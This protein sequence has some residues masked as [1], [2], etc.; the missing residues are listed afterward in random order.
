MTESIV[1]WSELHYPLLS[2]LR[3][4]VC[5]CE[6]AHDVVLAI[7]N[8]TWVPTNDFLKLCVEAMALSEDSE[9]VNERLSVLV[10]MAQSANPNYNWKTTEPYTQSPILKEMYKTRRMVEEAIITQIVKERGNV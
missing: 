3:S 6:R 9:D 5:P 8:C 2:L 4:S 1:V 7:L 10:K